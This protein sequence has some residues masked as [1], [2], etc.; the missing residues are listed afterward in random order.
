MSKH[1]TA[2]G[3][4]VLRAYN[5][6]AKRIQ[7][8]EQLARSSTSAGFIIPDGQPKGPKTGYQVFV[9]IVRYDE[10]LL[11]SSPK[12]GGLLTQSW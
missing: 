1:L 9:T 7:E 4:R 11:K 8:D 6:V 2:T 3:D 12:T 5:R 10:G